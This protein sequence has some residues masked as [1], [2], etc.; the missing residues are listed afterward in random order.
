MQ[1]CIVAC[2]PKRLIVKAHA[3]DEGAGGEDMDRA[4]VDHFS[5]EFEAQS[6]IRINYHARGLAKLIQKTRRCRE[7]L[8]ATKTA[9]IN[10]DCLAGDHDFR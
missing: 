9:Y 3:W 2:T 8:S 10:I 5:S 1:V 7:L 6:G 4:L